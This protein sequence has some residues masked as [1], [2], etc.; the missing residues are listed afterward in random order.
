MSSVTPR[1][2][3]RSRI[4]SLA[5]LLA[6]TVLGIAGILF[7]RALYIQYPVILAD[8]ELY[9]LHA[10]Y[11][12]NP[13]FAIQM[14]NVLFFLIYHSASWFGENHF[15]ITKLLNAVFFGMSILPLYAVAREFLS[16]TGAYFFSVAV[17]FSPISSYS[18]YMMPEA[19]FFFA[20]WVLAYVVVVKLPTDIIY[21]GVYLGFA[22]AALSAIKP[23]GLIIAG[24]FPVV[25]GILYF[26]NPDRM[27]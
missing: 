12:N 27:A 15:A 23:H 25:F 9:A 4:G 8:E 18:V 6:L 24:T 2:S 26:C 7:L 14:P 1:E 21:G 20:F 22:T 5:L 11:L 3:S 13:R 10:K 16:K 17:V 19:L